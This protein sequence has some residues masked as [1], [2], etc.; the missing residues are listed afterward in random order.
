MTDKET[1]PV[2]RPGRITFG[3]GNLAGLL[4]ER[5]ADL[6]RRE[7]SIPASGRIE[8]LAR[9][10]DRP[11]L[12]FT[13]PGGLAMGNTTPADGLGTLAPTRIRVQLP[14]PGTAFS[15]LIGLDRNQAQKAWRRP[16]PP[17]TGTAVFTIAV[18]GRE[19]FKSGPMTLTS[20]PVMATVDLAWAQEFDLP[21]R[22]CPISPGRGG[23][24]RW[25]PWPMAGSCVSRRCR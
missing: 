9:S 14:A 23:A 1:F 19:V 6:A 18:G 16:L 15:A 22:T 17:F 25:R 3:A 7:A 10:W 11:L 21:A 12:V 20:E 4:T 8:V 13:A 2:N 24:R 5:N